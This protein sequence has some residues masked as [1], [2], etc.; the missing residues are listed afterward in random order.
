M[1]EIKELIPVNKVALML[2]T[3]APTVMHLVM[4]MTVGIQAIK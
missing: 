3:L 4:M 1:I 2:H